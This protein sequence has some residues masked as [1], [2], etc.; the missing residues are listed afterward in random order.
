M[1][2]SRFLYIPNLIGY[3]RVAL[4]FIA[5]LG[6]E[7]HPLL[8]FF[9]YFFSQFL[10]M[11]DGAAA[12]RFNQATQFGAMLDM[13]TDRCSGIGL[14]LTLSH[15]LPKYT[16]LCH[17][18]IWIDI[19]SHWAHMLVQA[20]TRA[21]SHKKL[22]SGSFLLRFY[23]HTNWFMVLLIFGAEGGP[24]CVY[25]KTFP[26][27]MAQ[28]YAPVFNLLLAAAAPLFVIKHFINVLQFVRAAVMLDEKHE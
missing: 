13:V 2:L 1:A 23:Y 17:I 11:F 10:D 3:V 5:Y 26:E 12:R 20:R 16:I 6:S 9:C 25:V 27:V 22:E 4:M 15:R 7:T 18:L 28:W 24:C 19:C 8:F 14:F 21:T